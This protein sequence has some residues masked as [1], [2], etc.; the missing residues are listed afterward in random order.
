LKSQL[1]KWP[2]KHLGGGDLNIFADL[3]PASNPPCCAH[4]ISK[5]NRA[6]YPFRVDL[7]KKINPDFP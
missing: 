5:F 3:F 4:C 1:S 7:P 6:A 2:N